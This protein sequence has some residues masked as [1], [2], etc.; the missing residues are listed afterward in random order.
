MYPSST[1]GKMIASL[2]AVTGIMM[3]ALPLGVISSNFHAFEKY[4]IRFKKIMDSLKRNDLSK[5]TD[6]MLQHDEIANE[7]NLCKREM[8]ALYNR[9]SVITLL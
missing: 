9:D 7:E 8:I 5:H 3:L 2:C 1:L 4:S 6:M